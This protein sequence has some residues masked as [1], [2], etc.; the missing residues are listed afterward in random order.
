MDPNIVCII[1]AT[2]TVGSLAIPLHPSP[3]ISHVFSLSSCQTHETKSKSKLEI[4]EANVT[5]MKELSLINPPFAK[6][7]DFLDRGFL[8]HFPAS[9]VEIKW[10]EISE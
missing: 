6:R 4:N 7:L 5:I 10:R 3:I 9:C 8:A 1:L 2:S